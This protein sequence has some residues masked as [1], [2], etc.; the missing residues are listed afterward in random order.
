[1][2]R[3]LPLSMGRRRGDHLVCGYHGLTF[4]H[5]GN[6][7]ACPTQTR[8][9]AEAKVRS[10]PVAEKG[11]LVWIWMGNPAVAD[12][13]T[14]IEVE[15]NDDPAWRLTMGG[16]MTFAC[17]YLYLTDNLLDPSHVAWVHQTSFAASGTE[18]TPLRIEVKDDGV[19]VRRWIL[20]Q[21]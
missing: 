21:E 6:C 2:H 11:G 10:Y 14:L 15:N 5:A 12:D 13:S 20:D 1:C 9:P 8:I 4:D 17:N 18:D 3:K 16:A 19:T 7:V